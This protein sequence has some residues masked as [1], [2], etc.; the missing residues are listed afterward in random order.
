MPHGK[1]DDSKRLIEPF[2]KRW[3]YLPETEGSASLKAVL[4][5]LVPDLSY[6][7]LDIG[8]GMAAMEA[9]LALREEHDPETVRLT[10]EALWRH[11]E[12]D[13]LGMVRVVGR[14]LEL[15]GAGP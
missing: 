11:C 1:A 3:L 5:A 8:E 10:R 7:A 4:P 13:T 14:M 15:R 9:F 2:R 12:L 6:E